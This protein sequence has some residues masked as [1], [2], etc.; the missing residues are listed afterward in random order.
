MTGGLLWGFT[1][2]AVIGV[3]TPGLD[4]MIVL[5]HSVSGART[6]L[7]AVAGISVGCL[8]WGTA[9]V[10]GLTGL[11]TASEV[12][13]NVVRV[14]GAAY[15]LWLG[16][17]MLWNSLRRKGSD[18]DDVEPEPR[19]R[20]IWSALR[21]G[22]LTNLLNP[23]VGVFYMSLLPQF[24]PPGGSSFGWGALLVA[25]HV[26]AGAVWLSCV[27][28]AAGRM[29]VVLA[30]RRVRRWLDRV[31]ATVLISLGVKLVAEAA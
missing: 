8:V 15:L 31:M 21:A 16:S 5:R 1:L 20:T 10:V 2:V 12:A 22:F 7:A 3:M 25:I 28:W 26:T 13:F 4:T 30:R 19:E 29:R 27:V 9:S 11:L 17:T 18:V 24:L 6:G 23:K 14:L